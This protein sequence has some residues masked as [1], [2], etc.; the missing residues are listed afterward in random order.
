M[1]NHS[2]HEPEE[3]SVK[4]ILEWLALARGRTGPEEAAALLRHLLDLRDTPLPAAQRLK[5]LDLLYGYAA[6]ITLAQLPSLHAAT[7]PVSRRIR[8]LV[9]TIQDLLDI[10]AQDYLGAL[11]ESRALDSPEQQPATVNTLRR[12]IRCLAWHL[13]ISYLVSAP[14]GPGL[15][16]RLH[17]TFRT[18]RHRGLDAAEGIGN[19]GRIDRI[20]LSSL[21]LSV[22]QPAS[23]NSRE[24]EFIGQYIDSCVQA[25]DLSETAPSGHQGIFW[26]DPDRDTP[27]HALT[28]RLPPPETE[29]IY[30]ACDVVGQGAADHLAALKRGVSALEL[31]LP[32]FAESC[33]GRGV[34]KR[35]SNFWSYPAKRRFPRR[36]QSYRADLC[37]GLTPLWELLRTPAAPPP[38]SEWMITN[39]SPDGYAM[40]HVAGTTEQLRVGDIVAIQ[41]RRGDAA[42]G[43]G[44]QICI[45]RWALSENPEHIELGL[46]VMAGQGIPATLAL[47]ESQ[48][49]AG[50]T[51]T[52]LLLPEAPPLRT[53]RTLVVPAG[54]VSDV[55]QK[56]IV[57]VEQHNVAVH[58][59]RATRLDEQTSSIEMFSVEPDERP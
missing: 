49:R 52:A 1:P 12:A 58:E 15:W 38:T 45:V 42:A 9:R 40:M 26:I 4:P 8:Q 59:L 32:A 7:L 34:L 57:L 19:E 17:S 5:L 37:A 14:V 23:F 24:L 55:S 44:W 20:Y 54:T 29:I 36:R 16:Q 47:P 2:P 10:L 39:E 31:G 3:P 11:G 51:S 35:L 27:P 41:P 6:K 13:T 33:A 18:A 28:R 50:L 48:E 25:V 30:F 43:A 22:V 21:L 56:L 53:S 46:Q